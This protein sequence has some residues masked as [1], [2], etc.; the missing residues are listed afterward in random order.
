MAR[1]IDAAVSRWTETANPRLKAALDRVLEKHGGA[2]G[3]AL[4]LRWHP[5]QPEGS[6]RDELRAKQFLY[7]GL[8]TSQRHCG[9]RGYRR[10]TTLVYDVLAEGSLAAAV[11][12]NA[13]GL[14]AGEQPRGG[15]AAGLV[16]IIDNS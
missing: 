12:R 6:Y 3:R 4:E 15:T 14:I 5:A 9:A 10:R 2:V 1:I 7:A 13:P 8:R 11:D 16:L